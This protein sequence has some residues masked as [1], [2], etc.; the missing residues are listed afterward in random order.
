MSANPDLVRDDPGGPRTFPR[1]RSAQA[2]AHAHLP[3]GALE[4]PADHRGPLRKRPDL[5]AFVNLGKQILRERRE[6]R[7]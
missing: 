4:N 2:C 7:R 6:G 5:S 1:T 3:K